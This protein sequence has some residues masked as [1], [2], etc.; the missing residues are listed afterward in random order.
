MKRNLGLTAAFGHAKTGWPRRCLPWRP[1]RCAWSW[2]SPGPSSRTASRPWARPSAGCR[3]GRLAPGSGGDGG[4]ARSG[5]FQESGDHLALAPGGLRPSHRLLPVG[6]R[7]GGDF[8]HPVHR[9]LILRPRRR[10]E[11]RPGRA[12][13]GNVARPRSVPGGQAAQPLGADLLK[14]AG[15]AIPGPAPGGQPAY[16]AVVTPIPPLLAAAGALGNVQP[17]PDADG[18]YRRVPLVLPFKD[19]WLPSL[20]FAAFHRFG[21]P[22]PVRCPAPGALKVGGP[23]HS[24]GRPGAVPP[25][26]VARA[27]ATS[28]FPLPTS[29]PRRRAVG[30]A[31]SHLPGGGFRRQVGAGRAHRPGP[32]GPEGLSGVGHLS[33]GR[34]SC[35]PAG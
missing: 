1:W 10:S 14:R 34:G 11:V 12:A 2:T 13:A 33:R 7:Q 20:G 31:A 6:R 32:P 4:S 26:F 5:F 22:G 16:K 15:L 28:G 29:S 17:R 9:G 21:V 8:R 24:P 23:G 30:M 19:K 3:S 25:N 27:A 35:H 18:I